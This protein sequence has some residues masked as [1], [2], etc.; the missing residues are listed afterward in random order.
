M[1][2]STVILPSPRWRDAS[3][4]WQEA[5]AFGFFAGYTYDHLSWEAFREYPWF[6]AV[7]TL[8]AAALVTSTLKIGPLV[9]TPNFRHPLT[10][11]KDLIAIDDLSNGRVIAGVGSGSWGLDATVLGTER[12]S[13]SERH[14]RFEEFARTLDQ[15]LRESAS[16]I[17]GAFY[18]VHESR[19]LPG[20][21]QLPRPPL[22]M[23]A[24]GPKTLALTAEIADGWVSYGSP[25]GAGGQSTVVAASQQ[26][27][28]L[29]EALDARGRDASSFTKILLDF[30]GEA[31]PTSSLEAFLD[32]AGTY[33][34]LG[35]SEVVIHWPIPNSPYDYDRRTFEQ[36]ASEGVRT[37]S[38]WS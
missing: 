16:T 14:Q 37:V 35:F 5:E 15:L 19:Q 13:P 11:A 3:V 27:T 17:D 18:P 23:S 33:R 30:A 32:W 12:W 8:S 28:R 9:T 36:I 1:K 31:K 2:V 10:I 21:V 24:L 25:R 34:D 6:G 22:V 4:M 26:V 29:N 20:P 7:P 38:S